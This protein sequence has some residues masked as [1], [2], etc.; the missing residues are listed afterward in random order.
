M[1]PLTR[2]CDDL[3]RR[4]TAAIDTESSLAAKL[5]EHEHALMH[6]EVDRILALNGELDGFLGTL[7][8]LAVSLQESAIGLAE[9]LNL[10]SRTPLKDSL[11]KLPSP[12]REELI[13]L[14]QRLLLARRAAQNASNKNAAIARASLDA[15][16][17]VRELLGQPAAVSTSVAEPA[18]LSGR[19]DAEA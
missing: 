19:L 13:A 7:R 6:G 18:G 14:R 1:I 11:P 9:L 5:R 15:I 2:C 8:E 10:E 3:R 17:G 16:Q 4:L 12:E